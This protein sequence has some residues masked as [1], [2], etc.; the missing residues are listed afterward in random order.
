MTFP[1]ACS[2]NPFSVKRAAFWGSFF[3]SC[4]HAAMASANLPAWRAE[5]IDAT[6][7]ESEVVN[8]QRATTPTL[9]GN[10]CA[11]LDGS[12]SSISILAQDATE[13]RI[14]H[15]RIDIAKIDPIEHI[16]ELELQL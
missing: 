2:A 6:S 12:W 1:E 9:K 10:P 11:D 3:S 15:I 4:S 16:E 8:R 14:G 5:R 13:V 7:A